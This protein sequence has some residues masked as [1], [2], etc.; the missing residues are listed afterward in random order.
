MVDLGNSR[1]FTILISALFIKV[2]HL[3]Q[4]RQ[5]TKLACLMLTS[6]TTRPAT[7]FRLVLSSWQEDQNQSLLSNLGTWWMAI[8]KLANRWR[9]SGQEKEQENQEGWDQ[10][11]SILIFLHRSTAIIYRGPRFNYGYF[12][13]LAAVILQCQKQKSLS[14]GRITCSTLEKVASS[15]RDDLPMPW[16]PFTCKLSGAKSPCGDHYKWS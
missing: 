7:A 8:V 6:T 1:N 3:G 11:N 14:K 13:H 5:L 9:V 10:D 15:P 2:H 12:K 4:L 16:Y